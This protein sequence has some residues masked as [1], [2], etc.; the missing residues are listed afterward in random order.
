MR[1]FIA[2]VVA[3]VLASIAAVPASAMPIDN[4]P[5]PAA[6]VQRAAPIAPA[7][8]NGTPAFVY[9]LL[10]CGALAAFGAGGYLGARSVSRQLRPRAS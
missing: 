6:H 2:V 5:P 1:S 10:G 8:D 4:G 9:V 3:I 7:S